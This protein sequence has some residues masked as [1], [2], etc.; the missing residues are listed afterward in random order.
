VKKYKITHKINADFVAEIIVNEDDI[1]TQTN[2][3][4]EYKKPNSKFEYT[5]LKGTES[6]TQTIYEEYDE[7]TNNSIK[8]WTCNR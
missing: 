8:E 5:M 7:N 1:D 4:K 6:L 3:L 2:D